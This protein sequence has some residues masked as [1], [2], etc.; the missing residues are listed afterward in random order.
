MQVW[1]Q[2]GVRNRQVYLRVDL[3][4]FSDVYDGV[5][6]NNKETSSTIFLDKSC[7]DS[8]RAAMIAQQD[9]HF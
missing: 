8:S 4:Q 6:K 5:L 7:C 9:V 1:E 2:D 3:L